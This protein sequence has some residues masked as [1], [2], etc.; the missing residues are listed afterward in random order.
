MDNILYSDEHIVVIDKP[1]GYY[2]HPPEKSDYPIPYSEILL[3]RLRD[4]F[5]KK[6]Y[7]IHRLDVATSGVL[8][9]G[10][11]SE[12]ASNLQKIWQTD[13][14][15]KEYWAVARGWLALNEGQI[16]LPLEADGE[17]VLQN[18]L[19][20]YKKIAQTELP[21]AVGKKFSTSRYS[22]LEVRLAT[23]RWHQIRRHF[24]RI[25]H[26][27][28]GDGSH[29]DSH[30]NRFFR[31]KLGIAGLCLRAKS[32]RFPHPIS[33]TPLIFEAP[34]TE[35]WRKIQLLFTDFDAFQKQV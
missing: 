26:P 35:K 5:K 31:E 14:V 12:A 29:G 18:A 6:V 22:L 11:S 4:H 23:G 34:E 19:T 20:Y 16:D 17:G 21:F 24:N 27:L 1:P 25:S 10:F 33:E 7:P 13:L 28:I 8:V 15:Q 32:L 30:H 9:Y 3:Y 2:V